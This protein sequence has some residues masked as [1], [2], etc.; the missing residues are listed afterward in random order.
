MASPVQPGDADL[1]V[2]VAEGVTKSFSGVP[3]LRDGRLVLKRGSVHALCGGNGAGKSTFLNILMGLL[4]RD[5]GVVRLGAEVVEFKGPADA[6]RH[7]IA[8]I[9]Q[10]LSPIEDMTVAENLYLGEEP[11][12]GGVFVNFARMAKDAAT[13]LHDLGF[14][15]PA[16]AKMSDLSLAQIQLVEIAKALSYD[17]QIVIMDEPT[18]AIGEHEVHVL[19]NAMRRIKA[20]GSGIIYVSHKLTE[21]F[22]IADEYTVFRDGRFI[23]NGRIDAIDRKHLV[24]QIVGHEVTSVEKGDV[25]SGTSPMLEVRNL[26]GEHFQDISLQVRAGEVLGIYGL[27]GSGRTP[28]VETVYGIIRPKSGKVLLG[29]LPVP[30]GDTKKSIRLGMAMVTEDRKASGL[31]L[32]AS[33]AH[34]ITL[35]SLPQRAVGGF[36]KRSAESQVVGT[37]IRSQRIKTSSPALAVESLSGGNQQKVVF[38]RCLTTNPRLLLCDDPTRGIDEGSK[39]EIYT[40]LRQFAAKG[41]AVVVVSSEAPEILQVSDRIAIFKKGRLAEIVDGRTTTQKALMELAS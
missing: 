19:F 2:L 11:R 15:V 6:L 26:S 9:T 22:E 14:D 32:C 27:L 20:R 35:S 7:G 17:A 38:A 18:S 5:E 40:F 21:I 12:I 36:I 34:N 8:I 24:T 25:V 1:P 30:P 31:V 29:G 10:E 41:N 28:F 3:A 16:K 39:Q 4:P 33:I 37:M 23:E 13:L